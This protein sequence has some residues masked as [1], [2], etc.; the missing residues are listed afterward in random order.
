MWISFPNHIKPVVPHAAWWHTE[1][2]WPLLE[3]V[4][5]SHREYKSI[6][7]QSQETFRYINTQYLM[8]PSDVHSREIP[9]KTF[10][11]FA[12]AN[13]GT[14]F[15]KTCSLLLSCG[16]DGEFPGC[17]MNLLSQKESSGPLGWPRA[18][19]QKHLWSSDQ[20]PAL[21]SFSGFHF[22]ETGNNGGVCL[23]WDFCR[24]TAKRSA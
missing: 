17:V 6:N 12:K 10:L 7:R 23:L 19:W 16:Q 21:P 15:S 8:R 3:L 2:Q 13:V 24:V 20:A 4:S 5:E 14:T 1:K 9:N 22:L 18:I 11:T